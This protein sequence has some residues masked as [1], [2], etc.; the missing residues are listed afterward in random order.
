M[1]VS[2]KYPDLETEKPYNLETEARLGMK[3]W[4]SL[5]IQNKS[6]VKLGA[7]DL[8]VLGADICLA[9]ILGVFLVLVLLVERV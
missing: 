3:G 8:W 7:R 9:P 1:L 6:S 5:Q 4:L 2:T